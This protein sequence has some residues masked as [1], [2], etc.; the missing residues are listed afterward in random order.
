M[1]DSTINDNYSGGVA[2]LISTNS[3]VINSTID[4]NQQ[5]I[6]QFSDNCG[7]LNSIRSLGF[8]MRNSSISNNNLPVRAAV[9]LWVTNMATIE[10]SAISGNTAQAAGGMIIYDY[11][12]KL[13][14][15]ISHTTVNNN[16]GYGSGG[17][18][19]TAQQSGVLAISHTI[20]SGNT[21]LVPS[22]GPSLNPS[23]VSGQLLS[24]QD[25]SEVGQGAIVNV[26]GATPNDLYGTAYVPMDSFK[27]ID[28]N[29]DGDT[30]GGVLLGPGDTIPPG[31]T[32]TVIDG[33]ADNGGDSQTHMPVEGGLAVDGGTP[34]NYLPHEDQNYRIRPWDGDGDTTEVCDVGAVEFRSVTESDL[35]FKDGFQATILIRR[36]LV[37]N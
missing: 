20:T 32:S 16:E 1:L 2:D 11:N 10:N 7:V 9:D 4:G 34:F 27:V 21:Q 19:V 30:A 8:E 35:I 31:A 24:Q 33:L 37:K 15:Q 13:L 3:S 25:F 14:N 17:V 29:G 12:R 26:G 36:T 23:V 28:Q 18:Y 22:P 6:G 5:V